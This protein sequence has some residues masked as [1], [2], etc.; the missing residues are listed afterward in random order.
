MARIRKTKRGHIY[1]SGGNDTH[2]RYGT[3][4]LVSDEIAK[5][6]VEFVPLSDRVFQLQTTYCKMNIIHAPTNDKT[7]NE[8]EE[9]YTTLDE[10][11]KLTKKGE[12]TVMGDF[13]AKLGHGAEGQYVGAFG[14]GDRN[15]CGDRLAQFCTENRLFAANTFFKQHNRWLYT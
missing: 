13:N 7:E 10:A 3:A 11:M 12:I 8:V 9:F 14:L 2:H 15:S 6:I 4:I 5:S 1:Y